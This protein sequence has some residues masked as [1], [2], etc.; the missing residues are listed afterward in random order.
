ML[1]NYSHEEI[2]DYIKYPTRLIKEAN[3]IVNKAREWS[4]EKV[5]ESNI[6]K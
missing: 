2:L 6:V 5:K 1:E 3:D 4:I